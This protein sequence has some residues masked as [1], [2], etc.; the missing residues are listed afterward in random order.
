MPTITER[1]YPGDLIRHEQENFMS[2]KK[3]TVKSGAGALKLGTI[4]G[5]ILVGAAAA[6][7][8]AGN[9]ANTGACGA[10]TVS[11]GAKPG[12]YKVVMIEPGTNAGKFTVED[13][14]GIMVGTGT[15]AVAFTGGGLSFT[16]ADGATDFS[17]G[18]GFT[19]TVAA[20][21]GK[22]IPPVDGAA[23]GSGVGDVVLLE[24]IDATDADVETV[25]LYRDAQIASDFL[26]YDASID[27]DTKKAAVNAGLLA[28]NIQFLDS[29]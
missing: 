11:E 10:V 16:I 28:N 5:A 6:A 4:L 21:S 24:D 18:E 14:D 13:P 7:A 17:S 3:V 20:G 2:R 1:N 25:A 8:F 23:D 12:D 26:I 29:I 27:D 9:A 22:Y 19:I 15:V